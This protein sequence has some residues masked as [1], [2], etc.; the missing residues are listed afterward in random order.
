[1]VEDLKFVTALIVA[2]LL[3]LRIT[4]LGDKFVKAKIAND[5]SIAADTKRAADALCWK[6]QAPSCLTVK[7]SYW[8]GY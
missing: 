8:T 5:S 2:A 6:S 3:T 7:T 4:A 1:M